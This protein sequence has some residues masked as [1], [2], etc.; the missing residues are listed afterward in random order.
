MRSNIFIPHR[1]TELYEKMICEHF[2]G[3]LEIENDLLIWTLPSG[4]AIKI[5]IDNQPR[6]GYILAC[7]QKGKR[8]VEL[9]HW[10]P[11][12][13]EIYEDLYKI[14]TGQIFWMKKKRALFTNYPLYMEKSTW[15]KFSEKRKAK[16]SIL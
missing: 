5:V 15:E 7:Y 14:N 6:E 11:M 8:E 10:H 2:A 13:D 1:V 4:I 3:Q 9:T 16:Y 12:E